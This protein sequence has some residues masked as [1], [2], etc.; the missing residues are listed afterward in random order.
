[1]ADY[2]KNL[3]ISVTYATRVIKKGSKNCSDFIKNIYGKR[4]D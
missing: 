2:L 3:F 1:V 4:P